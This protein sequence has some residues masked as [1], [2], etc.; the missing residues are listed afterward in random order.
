[1]VSCVNFKESPVHIKLYLYE[2][3]YLIYS[4]KN[5]CYNTIMYLAFLDVIFSRYLSTS[6]HRTPFFVTTALECSNFCYNAPVKILVCNASL[7]T[8]YGLNS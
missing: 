1:M 2:K 7:C 4:L 5:S 3:I 6:P 8:S